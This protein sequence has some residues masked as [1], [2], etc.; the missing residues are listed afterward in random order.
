MINVM[1]FNIRGATYDDGD[2]V[3]PKRSQLN[4]NTIK[5]HAPDVIGFQEY[6]MGNHEVYENK[7][8]Q[9]EFYLGK[10]YNR[11]KRPFY[12]TIAFKPDKMELVDINTFYLSE[13]PETWSSS[14]DA[15]RV[16][17]VNWAKLQLLGS[18][19]TLLFMNTHLD[20]KSEWARRE[21]SYLI[22]K[23]TDVLNEAGLPLILMGD[24]NSSADQPPRPDSIFAIF[25]KAGFHDSW[26][27]TND[28]TSIPTNTFHGFKGEAMDKA[29]YPASLRLDWILWKNGR[30]PLHATTCRIIRDEAPPIYP[31]DHY[32]IMAAFSL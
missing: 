9:Y 30:F 2:N 17:T 31:S 26:E 6:Q 11:E 12:N 29:G 23:M 25:E 5:Q 3:W 24:F 27:Q 14:W 16:H 19:K 8:P 10:V 7:L 28:D 18:S 21:S 13:T 4:V 15:A 22:V 1:S 20:H 32:P